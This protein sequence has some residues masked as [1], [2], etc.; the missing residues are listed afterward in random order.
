M[1]QDAGAI[2]HRRLSF[3]AGQPDNSAALL[4]HLCISELMYQPAA[5]SEFEFIELQNGVLI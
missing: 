1:I 4:E 2:G 5:S 3:V